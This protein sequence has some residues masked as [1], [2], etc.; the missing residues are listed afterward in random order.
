MRSTRAKLAALAAAAVV[1]TLL[2]ASVAFNL[3]IGWKIESDA[4]NDIEYLLSLND[5]AVSTGR[6]PNYFLV[7]ASYRISG[8]DRQWSTQ[9][10]EALAMWFAEHPETDVVNRVSL[11]GWTCYAA[12]TP[13]ADYDTSGDDAYGGSYPDE[14]AYW[15]WRDEDTFQDGYYIAYVDIASEQALVASVNTAFVIIALIGAMGAAAAGYMAGRRIDEAHEAQKRFYENMSHDLKTPLAAIRGY[16]EGA[17]GGV[18]GVDEATRAIV[19]ETDRMTATINEILSLS[20]LEAG[21]VQPH[22]ELLEV[23]DFAQDCLMPFEGV[24]RSR[25]IDV[26]LDLAVGEVEADPTLFDHALSNVLTNAVHHAVTCVRVT[27]DGARLAVWNDGGAPEPEQLAHLFDRYHVGEGGSTGV[28][29]AITGEVAALHG[30][31]V[32]ARAVDDGLEIAFSF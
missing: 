14:P 1:A 20:R 5:D 13:M 11:D 3:F 2:A 24:V 32:S 27:Y 31:N 10:E 18:V 26:Q 6:T 28:G 4:V 23:G 22:K 7:D 30:W 17:G 15:S 19:R 29:L 21:A 16:A 8:P 12:L 9:D 25:G